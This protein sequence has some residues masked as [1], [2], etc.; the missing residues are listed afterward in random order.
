MYMHMHVHWRT[1]I[2]ARFST[3]FI[4]SFIRSYYLFVQCH[5]KMDTYSLAKLFFLISNCFSH[6]VFPH[7]PCMRSHIVHLHPGYTKIISLFVISSFCSS[8]SPIFMFPHIFYNDDIK[9]GAVA[10]WRYYVMHFGSHCN[11]L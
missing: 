7:F 4:F 10:S 9:E 5:H 1:G 8:C 11:T 6:F 3:L 2:L